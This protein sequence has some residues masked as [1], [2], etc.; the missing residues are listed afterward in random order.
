MSR[1]PSSN[2][3]AKEKARLAREARLARFQQTQTE[4][5]KAAAKAASNAKKA[6]NNAVAEAKKEREKVE[7][8][9]KIAADR[10]K[11]LAQ[12]AAIKAEQNA[13]AQANSQRRRNSHAMSVAAASSPPKTLEELLDIAKTRELLPEEK[14]LINKL[15]IAKIR[16]NE[17]QIHGNQNS[18]KKLLNTLYHDQ[19]G[20][21]PQSNIL[22]KMLGLPPKVRTIMPSFKF[23]G[24]TGTLRKAINSVKNSTIKKSLKRGLSTN[25]ILYNFNKN[26]NFFFIFMNPIH[27]QKYK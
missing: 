2:N 18:L 11:R 3:N 16:R 26:I 21:I 6:L 14:I 25:S 27:N 9:A 13:A 4:E 23:M 10:E 5:Q 8:L 20:E 1:S 24:K 12:N 7:R 19:I 17:N 15:Y 22:D